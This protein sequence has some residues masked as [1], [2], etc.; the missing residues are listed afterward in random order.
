MCFLSSNFCVTLSLSY[1]VGVVIIRCP[2]CENNHLIADNLGWFKDDPVN[3]ETMAKEK[4][5]KVR[6]LANLEEL[7][8]EEDV[9]GIE[10]FKELFNEQIKSQKQPQTSE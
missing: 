10:K 6:R 9:E 1:S 5:Q 4:G 7:N 2:S 3:V 8:T